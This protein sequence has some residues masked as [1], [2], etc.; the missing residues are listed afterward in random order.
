MGPGDRVPET[1]T[2]VQ[3]GDRVEHNTVGGP[4]LWTHVV[5]LEGVPRVW[6][7]PPLTTTTTTTYALCSE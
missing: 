3:R 5:R 6:D 4:K 2:G 7:G 1:R